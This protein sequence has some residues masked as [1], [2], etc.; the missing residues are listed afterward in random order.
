MTQDLIATF[1]KSN[2]GTHDWTFKDLDP[3]LS[4]I[5]IKEACELLTTLNLFEQ[6]G[7]TLFD[8]VVTA[9]VRVYEERLV[10]D[11][12]HEPLSENEQT[13]ETDCQ[14]LR[15]F[16][17]SNQQDFLSIAPSHRPVL[18]PE[19]S[20]D[21]PAVA[22]IHESPPARLTEAM[23]KSGWLQRLFRRRSRNKEDPYDN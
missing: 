7:V 13:T 12:E 3:D 19:E 14:A 9:K 21:Q 4:V 11:P 5:E 17:V 23:T 16:N 6:D 20:A 18:S 2:G 8:S 22:A 1:G 10:F 15:C